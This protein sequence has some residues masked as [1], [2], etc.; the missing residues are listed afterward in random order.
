MAVRLKTKLK[1]CPTLL[2]ILVRKLY[3]HVGLV[4]FHGYQASTYCCKV[5][6]LGHININKHKYS[7]VQASKSVLLT[8]NILSFDSLTQKYNHKYKHSFTP[9]A[10]L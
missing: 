3:I 10:I 8:I 7:L 2:C 1:K 6:D 9:E 5:Y 4:V